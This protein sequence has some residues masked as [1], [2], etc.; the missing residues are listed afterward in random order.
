MRRRTEASPPYLCDPRIHYFPDKLWE[1]TLNPL[2]INGRPLIPSSK[3]PTNALC[4][5]H[6]LHPLPEQAKIPV[7]LFQ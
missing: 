4:A 1:D 5:V 6:P 2:T 7:T 3:A